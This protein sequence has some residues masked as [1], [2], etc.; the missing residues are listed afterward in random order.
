MTRTDQQVSSRYLLHQLN[1][2]GQVHTEIDEFP[3]NTFLLVF[4]LLKHEHVVVEELLQ[5]LVGEVDAKLLKAVELRMVQSV[6]PLKEAARTEYKGQVLTSKISKPAISSTPINWGRACPV[7]RV[8]LQ[9]LTSH[10][11]RRSN[12]ALAMAPME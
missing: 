12:T 3:V 7:S 6:E 10:L 1:A 11:K 5:L 2:S 9:R 8:S 4:F